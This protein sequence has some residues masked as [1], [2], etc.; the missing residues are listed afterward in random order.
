MTSGNLPLEDILELEHEALAETG[1][2]ILNG[3]LATIANLLQRTLK[4][5]LPEILRGDSAALFNLPPPPTPATS[6]CSSTSISRFAS[7]TSRAISRCLMD[8]PSLEASRS[9]WTNSSQNSRRPRCPRMLETAQKDLSWML[10]DALDLGVALLDGDRRVVAWNAWLA[11]ARHFPREAAI[12]RRLEDLF[13]RG[14]RPTRFY[15]RVGFAA[16]RALRAF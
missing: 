5:S 6:S 12:G 16:N 8:L 13:P 1:N 4:I 2:I 10:F 3:C 14:Q 7:A 9:C 15:R 11:S